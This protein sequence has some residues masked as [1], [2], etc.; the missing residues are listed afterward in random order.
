MIGTGQLPKFEA[1]L[2]KVD[3]KFGDEDGFLIPTA[4]VPVTNIFRNTIV[5]DADLPFRMVCHSP[6]FRAEAGSYGR[7]TRGE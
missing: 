3:H 1:D 5:E 7:D 2:F 4:E 6:S